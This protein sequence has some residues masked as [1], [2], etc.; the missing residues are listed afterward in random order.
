LGEKEIV[1]E[2]RGTKGD[3]AMIYRNEPLALAWERRVALMCAE[4]APK[5][6]AKLV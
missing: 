5:G 3:R 4:G 6:W 1:T 2:V